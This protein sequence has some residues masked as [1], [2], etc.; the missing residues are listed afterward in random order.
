M[1]IR[2]I[3]TRRPGGS[4]ATLCSTGP[5][6]WTLATRRP[7]SGPL[8]RRCRTT[9]RWSAAVERRPTPWRAARRRVDGFPFRPSNRRVGD[10]CAPIRTVG[11]RVR[12]VPRA[13]PSRL[14][15]THCWLGAPASVA[16][17]VRPFRTNDG[18]GS[19][20]HGPVRWRSGIQFNFD[21]IPG[22]VTIPS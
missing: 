10:W 3:L 1:R 7:T 4:F 17:C 21:V 9:R 20:V 8:T 6:G 13:R 18:G 14:C 15:A 16:E 2:I 12:V 22:P 11:C 19:V 5:G